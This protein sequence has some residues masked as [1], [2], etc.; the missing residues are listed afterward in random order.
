MNYDSN[1]HLIHF[2]IAVDYLLMLTIF[3]V[4][5]ELSFWIDVYVIF[6]YQNICINYTYFISGFFFEIVFCACFIFGFICSF[7][8]IM[9]SVNNVLTLGAFDC[10]SCVINLCE[11]SW[12]FL[13]DSF[14]N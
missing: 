10:S 4:Q 14:Q 7:G 11:P 6:L 13:S 2:N 5:S 3:H 1:F 8:S 12:S 9:F